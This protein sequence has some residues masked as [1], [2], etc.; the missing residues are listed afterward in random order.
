MF[1][2]SIVSSLKD[3]TTRQPQNES[4]WY[5]IWNAILS[6]FF[7]SEDGYMIAPQTIVKSISNEYIIPDFYIEIV[8]ISPNLPLHRRIVAI[9]EIKNTSRWPGWKERIEEQ[10]SIQADRSF[11]ETAENFVYCIMAVGPHWKY[12][13]KHDNGQGIET[14]IPWHDVIH[15]EASY[16]DFQRLKERV[17]KM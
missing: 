1:N 3:L 10:I 5:G 9:L 12:G 7:P 2:S 8:K 16:E 14:L 4:E 17:E 11:D 13:V 6:H 15:N